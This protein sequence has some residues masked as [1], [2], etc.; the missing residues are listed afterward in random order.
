MFLALEVY[1]F[2]GFKV[3]G[4][5]VTGV[6]FVKAAGSATRKQQHQRHIPNSIRKF[7]AHR[8]KIAF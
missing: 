8:V 1:G 5:G 6:R 2:R 4:V 7:G 3:W